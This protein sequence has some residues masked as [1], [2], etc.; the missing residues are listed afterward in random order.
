[1]AK[2]ESLL[3]LRRRNDVAYVA[4][5]STSQALVR[6][7]IHA[8]LKTG[9]RVLVASTV[10]ELADLESKSVLVERL[11]PSHRIMPRVTVAI[12]AGGQG[13]VQ[14]AVAAGVPLASIPL[15]PEQ[16]LNVHLVQRQGMAI[17]VPPQIAS[18]MA[19]TNAVRRLFEQPSYRYQAGRLRGIVENVD[20]PACVA[21]AIVSYLAERRSV[22]GSP[23][24]TRT[25]R[26]LAEVSIQASPLKAR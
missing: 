1:M 10:H 7:V 13:S 20:G 3:R 14:T 6:G 17:L 26:S 18:S 22:Q 24:S 9:L 19:M 15:Q 2:P 11:L 16:D 25:E 12:T 23:A 21:R 4:L 5:T 8:V